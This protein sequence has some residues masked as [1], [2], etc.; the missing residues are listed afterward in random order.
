MGQRRH[1]PVDEDR[2]LALA[3]KGLAPRHRRSVGHDPQHHPRVRQM[4]EQYLHQPLRPV[5]RDA[6]RLPQGQLQLRRRRRSGPAHPGLQMVQ[7][8]PRQPGQIETGGQFRDLIRRRLGPQALA[9]IPH[10]RGRAQAQPIRHHARQLVVAIQ[11]RQKLRFIAGGQPPQPRRNAA[12][13]AQPLQPV[14]ARPEQRRQ[15]RK[16]RVAPTPIQPLRLDH[17][18]QRPRPIPRHRRRQRFQLGQQMIRASGDQLGQSSPLR[19]RQVRHPH[20]FGRTESRPRDQ[21]CALRV[22][23]GFC[24][25][26]KT[27]RR[28][29]ARPKG[30]PSGTGWPA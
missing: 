25:A 26:A 18:A 4:G 9:L 28:P 21:G 27:F 30:G 17:V 20:S 22:N 3:Q 10:R 1:H 19:D 13:K 2:Q 6:R 7:T 14:G 5:R 11:L 24:R 15:R 29:F 16:G 23:R 8:A 12:R